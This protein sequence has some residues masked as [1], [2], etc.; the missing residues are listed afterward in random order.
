M[1]YLEHNIREFNSICNK[2]IVYLKVLLS[3]ELIVCPVFLRNTADTEVRREVGWRAQVAGWVHLRAQT[4][5]GGLRASGF[6]RW[7]RKLAGLGGGAGAR[8]PVGGGHTQ[9]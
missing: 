4:A 1:I 2:S 7:A 5:G 6:W 8:K 3:P 9:G